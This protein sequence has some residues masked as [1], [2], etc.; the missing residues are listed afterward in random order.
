MTRQRLPNRLGHEVVAFEHCG[1]R[2]LAGMGRFGDGRLAEMFLNGAKCGTGLDTAAKD[3]A[4]L[5]SLNLQAGIPVAVIR[6]AL[7]RNGDGS[8]SGPLGRILDI[9]AVGLMRRGNFVSLALQARRAGSRDPPCRIR[10][11]R[12]R[13][14]HHRIERGIHNDR[15]IFRPHYR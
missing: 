11:G 9:V 7:T 8:P 13:A 1:V 10:S 6:R 15:P 4:I 5:C 2:Y 3:A 12:P 14:R